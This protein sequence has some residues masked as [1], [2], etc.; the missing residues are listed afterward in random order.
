MPDPRLDI[1]LRTADDTTGEV[2]RVLRKLDER[3]KLLKILRVQA[4]SSTTFR[5][6]VLLSSALM[7][8]SPL[9]ADVREVVVLHLA[10]RLGVDYEWAEHVPMSADAGVTDAQREAL[11]DGTLDHLE[12]FGEAQRLALDV[13][14]AMMGKGPVPEELWDRARE[15]WGPE[16]AFDLVIAVALWGGFVPKLITAVGL[17]S[18]AQG[19]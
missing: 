15:A 7:F 12:G 19:S 8:D 11:H 16:A 18:P 4:N 10:A 6:F 5:P 13:A 3:G 1:P 9:P 2:Q 17:Q 14:D